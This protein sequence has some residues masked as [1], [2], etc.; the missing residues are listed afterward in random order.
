MNTGIEELPKKNLAGYF[1]AKILLNPLIALV[2][3]DKIKKKK[4]QNVII[5]CIRGQY[6]L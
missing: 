6:N 3:D 4:P 1:P 2:F 5:C